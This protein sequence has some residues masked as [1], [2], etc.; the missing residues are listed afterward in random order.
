MNLQEHHYS[1]RIRWTGNLGSGT[2]G[3]R[4]YSRDHEVDVDGPGLLL[5]TADPTF[6]GTKERWNPE[7]L[8]LAAVA[9]CHMLSY[10]H[11]AVKNGVIVTGY[12]DTATGSLRLNRDGS[13]E[14]TGVVLRPHVEL[15]DEA[16]ASLAD[17][18]HGE[19]NR[20]CFIARSV[21]FPVHHEPTS[22]P[23]PQHS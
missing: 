1:A 21:N 4:S 16:Q 14:F 12:R 19:A 23:T 15:L 9:Q 18:L 5:G 6:H 20:L 7:Q 8:L 13:G 10:L 11:V 17:S 2:S 3:Y 22:G